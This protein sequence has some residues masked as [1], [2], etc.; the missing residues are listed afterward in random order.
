MSDSYY[1]LSLRALYI[2]SPSQKHWKNKMHQSVGTLCHITN[3]D[4]PMQPMR[5]ESCNYLRWQ[6]G[7]KDDKSVHSLYTAINKMHGL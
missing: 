3:P 6:F 1:N 4:L 5:P 7:I 2:D